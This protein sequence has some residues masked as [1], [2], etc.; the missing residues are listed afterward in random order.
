MIKVNNKVLCR[1]CFSEIQREPCP[2]CGFCEEDYVHDPMILPLG[3]I[4]ENRYIIGRCIGKGGFGI[5]YLA[6]DKKLECKVAIKEYYPSNLVVRNTKNATVSVFDEQS[7]ETFKGGADKFYDE[8]RLVAQ[9]NENPNVVSVHDFF[10]ANDT[11]YFT[12]GFLK[13]MT[14]K[15]YIR[16]N[17]PLSPEQVVCVAN[18]I[19]NALAIAH[20]LNVLHRDISPANIMICSD[21]IIKLLDFG[22]AR[23]IV[24]EGSQNLSVIL[25]RG[26][27]PLEQ[28][29]K[30]GNQGPWTDIYALGGTLYNAL[31][32]DIMEDPMSRLEDDS[33]YMS[34]KH[35]IEESLWQVIKKAT[36]LKR[37]DRYQDIFEFQ[38]DI[39]SLNIIPERIY[40]SGIKGKMEPN[41]SETLPL[42]RE[43]EKLG[44][45]MPADGKI[46]GKDRIDMQ[47]QT[48]TQEKTDAEEVTRLKGKTIKKIAIAVAVMTIL[49][50]AAIGAF[51]RKAATA[52]SNQ[53]NDMPREQQTVQEDE[54]EEAMEGNGEIEEELQISEENTEISGNAENDKLISDTETPKKRIAGTLKGGSVENKDVFGN[55]E[56]DRT[57]IETISFLDTQ[58]DLGENAWDVSEEQNKSVMAWTDESRKN[59]YL[60]G[61]GNIAIKSA[62]HLFYGY[63]NVKEIKFNCVLDTSRLTDMH[64]MF[65]ECESL[66][67]LDL[68]GFDTSNVT[69]MVSV[70]YGCSSLTELDLSVFD[71]KKVTDMSWMFANCSS[72]QSL[73]V[74]G[75][76]TSRVRDINRMFLACS[77]LMEL[78]LSRF[79]TA[80]V[81]DMSLMFYKC[82]S[83]EN[84]DLS[85]F[86]TSQVTDMSYM[87]N[88]CSS[89]E[90]LDLSN[91]DTSR[92]TNMRSMF[93]ECISLENLNVSSFDTKQTSD[94]GW[95]FSQC[96]SLEILDIS[97]F[98]TSQVEDMD[99]MFYGCSGLETLDL[100]GFDTVRV[101]DM[102]NMFLECNSLETLDLSS[103]DTARV[104]D[105][106]SMFKECN[107]L[108]DLNLNGF[109]TSQVTNMGHMF[110]GC[111]SLKNLDLSSFDTSQA[112][113]M[114]YMF[115]RCSSLDN[116]KLDNFD[117]S[118]VTNDEGIFDDAGI[119]E[120][121]T[122]YSK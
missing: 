79:D 121:E 7:E 78:D 94:M 21:G 17:G 93:S 53:E 15:E 23:H 31:T 116:L 29:Q 69:K 92:V 111:G 33:E 63:T 68:T 107:S 52:F 49:A 119:T 55:S 44:I 61:D 120:E 59:L 27:A 112:T 56:L 24:A 36:E 87:F 88:E 76:E 95:M 104:K 38:R 58:A 62:Y 106:H 6:Y 14:L 8:A 109:N 84:L 18:D 74:S 46:N 64:G 35:N 37:E 85:N 43:S 57:S 12:M 60:A 26:F 110:Y 114:S 75:F 122:G 42:Q 100:S 50:A 72:L 81:T 4:L 105:M 91:F 67:S 71:T 65:S 103:F 30:K 5:T 73:N 48:D 77:N 70:F 86:D 90:N 113:D 99:C 19:S 20:S 39:N 54:S 9:F 80:K 2:M 16:E 11:A 118:Q 22:A 96:S 89:L 32:L 82:S 13:G 98:Y 3:S 1:N 45:T 28:Y 47:E 10:Y 66:E 41:M 25:T 115:Y 40:A 97:S 34:N 51:G 108:K 101:K 83:L 117:T 102:S